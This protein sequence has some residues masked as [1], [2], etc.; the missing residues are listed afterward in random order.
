MIYRIDRLSENIIY[1]ESLK[2][3]KTIGRAECAG[4]RKARKE[5]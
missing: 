4:M 5:N 2:I 1:I 3:E